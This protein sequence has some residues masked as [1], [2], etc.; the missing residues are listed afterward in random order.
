MNARER[1]WGFV[2]AK[3]AK[4]KRKAPLP[5]QLSLAHARVPGRGGPRVGA[6]R[7]KA[8]RPNVRHRVR[9]VHRRHQP[10]HVTLRCAKGIPSLRA[11]RM[12]RLLRASIARSQREGFRI[13][14]YSL[15]VDHV[16][17]V[18]EADDG[19]LL[20]QGMRAFAIRVATRI[21]RH[22]FGRRRGKVWADRYHRRD[23]TNPTAVRNTLIYVLKNF[24]KHGVGDVRGHIDPCSSA[25]WFRGWMQII[26]PPSEPA[27]VAP[28]RTWLLREGW[29]TV[30]HGL[31]HV[32]ELPRAARPTT[33]TRP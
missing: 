9:P 7:K 30:G 24:A 8:A 29:T 27:A 1:V 28:A 11:E 33:A 31:L 23:L 15:Q 4:G 18:V 5:A 6:G 25:P 13:A 22:I 19:A 12:E 20:T 32:G 10:V 26:E 2:P 14:E 3:R 17:M 16:H 21:N